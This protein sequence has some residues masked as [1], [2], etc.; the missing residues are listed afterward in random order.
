MTSMRHTTVNWLKV[1][2]RIEA[3]LGIYFP[4]DRYPDMISRLQPVAQELEFDDVAEFAIWLLTASI[5]SAEMA[6]L[7]KHLTIGETYFFRGTKNFDALRHRIFPAIFNHS[8]PSRHEVRVWSAA[9]STGEEPYSV[10]I[11]LNE[12]LPPGWNARI[13]AS[14][15]NPAA[16]AQAQ[17]GVYRPWSFRG[18]SPI[19]RNRYFNPLPNGHFELA[20]NIRQMV[21]FFPFNLISDEYPSLLNG[22]NNVDMIFCRNVL[23]YFSPETVRNIIRKMEKTLV[24]DG[25]LLVSPAEAPHINLPTLA[26][27]NGETTSCFQKRRAVSKQPKSV[28]PRRRKPRTPKPHSVHRTPVARPKQVKPQNP[29][30]QL[31]A[32]AV[33]EQARAAY[34]HGDYARAAMILEEFFTDNET[35]ISTHGEFF[36]HLIHAY[37]NQNNLKTAEVWCHR[38]IERD[39]INPLHYYL[40]ATVYL[41]QKQTD[42]TYDALKKAVFLD[43]NFIMAHFSLGNLYQRDG[44]FAAAERQYR[45]LQK[46]LQ[47]VAPETTLPGADDLTAAAVQKMAQ[48]LIL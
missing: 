7:S 44:E 8:H 14:D 18:L 3:L 2:K 46:L 10:A 35:A 17:K 27:V 16:I 11:L 37:A 5:S 4:P 25:Y 31:P 12:L 33:G 38:A 47:N 21:E 40:L 13:F 22:L 34:Q 23:I 43:H 19:Y 24:S 9:C 39:K 28:S 30:F 42:A 36:Q 41:A 29:V 15:V 1:S 6:V 48:N 32:V 26:R 45:I 20:P